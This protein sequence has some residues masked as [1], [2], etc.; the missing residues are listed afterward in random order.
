MIPRFP[1]FKPLDLSDCTEVTVHTGRF[2]PYSDF[3]FVSLSSWNIR[4][5]FRLSTL[6]GN[7]VV[8]FTD[9]VTG[10]PFYSFMGA[11]QLPQTAEAL[12]SRSLSEGLSERLRLIP[13]EVALR[14][15]GSSASWEPDFDSS[16][17]ILSSVRLRRFEGTTF[18]S[19]R[20]VSN[21][22][23]RE[24]PTHRVERIDPSNAATRKAMLDL[25][26]LWAS[27]KGHEEPY[28][29]YEFLALKRL[30][31]FSELLPELHCTGVFVGEKMAAFMVLEFV[32]RKHAIGH[33]WKANV[34]EFEGVY[35]FLMRQTGALLEERGYDYFNVEQD[36]GLPGLRQ[37]KSSYVPLAYLRK[38]EVGRS[39]LIAQPQHR[40]TLRPSLRPESLAPFLI[41]ADPTS[42]NDQVSLRAPALRPDL[43][44]LARIEQEAEALTI[45]RSGIRITGEAT[46]DE[47][48][49][50]RSAG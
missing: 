16:D 15:P 48:P 50:K 30:L 13:E 46:D 24:N 42:L 26:A 22:F 5:E 21:R 18:R 38:Y 27:N 43:F 31:E 9:Y 37:N 8:R 34:V 35:P 11:H 39:H 36:L 33:F 14:L 17:Y 49:G 28:E 41:S 10:E 7:L 23:A 6:H 29:Q 4:D 44:E 45:R 19:K 12:L 20:N 25:F 2:A 1:A 47:E 3:N 40:A 32:H